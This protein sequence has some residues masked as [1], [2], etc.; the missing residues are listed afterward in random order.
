MITTV[1]LILLNILCLLLLVK[2]HPRITS[3]GSKNDFPSFV[4]QHFSYQ[5]HCRIDLWTLFSIVSCRLIVRLYVENKSNMQR[6]YCLTEHSEKIRLLCLTVI[7]L[8]GSDNQNGNANSAN[9][10]PNPID[11]I[12]KSINHATNLSVQLANITL[13]GDYFQIQF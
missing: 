3:M 6:K 13:P 11:T 2:S 12:I 10:I 5:Y 4:M 9:N 8:L 7:P 1:L